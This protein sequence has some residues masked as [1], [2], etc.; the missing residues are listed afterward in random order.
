MTELVQTFR[1]RVR[2]TR[3]TAPGPTDQPPPR[4]KGDTNSA[5]STLPPSGGPDR[6]GD[7]GFQDCSGLGLEADLREYLEGGGNDRV[8]RRTGRVK[9]QPLVLKRGMFCATEGGSADTGLWDWLH[10]MVS[11]GPPAARYDGDVEVLDPT[12]ERVV[13]HWTFTR[14][15]PL[16]VNGPTLNAKTGEIA[17]EELHIAHEGLRLERAR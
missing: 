12:G 16:K 4:L 5:P 3:S 15:L 7:G 11:G 6:L 2:L 1:F 10:G 17:M 13:A 14:G 8:V 9:L